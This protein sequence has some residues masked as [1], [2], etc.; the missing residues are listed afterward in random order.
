[1]IGYIEYLGIPLRIAIAL[2]VIFFAMQAIGEFLEFK[3]KVVPEFLKIRKTM[4]QRKKDREETAQT[5]K[6]VKTLFHEVNAHYSSDNITK[7]NDWMESVNNRFA[8]IYQ[9][10]GELTKILS[11][12]SNKLDKNNEDTLSLLIDSKRNEII[13]FASRVANS[14]YTV[15]REQYNRIFKLYR[16]YEDL[17]ATNGLTNGEVDIVYRIITE[18]Y[19]DRLKNNNFV[20]DIR[21]YTRQD[22]QP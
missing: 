6:E 22:Q 12:L 21:G 1:M 4:T 7:R 10:Q 18:S 8:D 15:T 16:E 9:Q 5:L 20:E 3:G 13:D 2:V 11:A 19:E 17:I 14:S